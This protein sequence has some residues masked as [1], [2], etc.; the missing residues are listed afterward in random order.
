MLEGLAIIS[1]DNLK[2]SKLEQKFVIF[3]KNKI[4]KVLENLK[5][6]EHIKNTNDFKNLE[7]FYQRVILMK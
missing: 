6:V 4:R 5:E 3:S 1:T 7:D 2:N